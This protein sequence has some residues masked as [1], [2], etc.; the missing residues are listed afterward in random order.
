MMG[1]RCGQ[2]FDLD[3]QTVVQKLSS[4]HKI[5]KKFLKRLSSVSKSSTRGKGLKVGIEQTN[6]SHW[7][8]KNKLSSSSNYIYVYAYIYI[9]THTHTHTCDHM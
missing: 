8:A 6:L 1:W 9:Y 7:E 3:E 5:K 2:S 4:N